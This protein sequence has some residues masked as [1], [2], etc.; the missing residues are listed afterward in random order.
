MHDHTLPIT[1]PRQFLGS[2]ERW[3]PWLAI[4]AVIAASGVASTGNL[5]YVMALLATLAGLVIAVYP[6]LLLWITIVAALVVAG[7]TRLYIPQ[8]QEVRWFVVPVALALLG[9]AL[10]SG[11]TMTPGPTRERL[12]ATLGW[13]LAFI[14]VV[15]FSTLLNRPGLEQAVIGF[16]GYFQVWGVL[17]ALAILRWPVELVDR[18]P[19][20][21]LWIGLLQLP[22]ALHQYLSMVPSRLGLGPGIVPLDVVSGTFGADSEGGGMNALLATY[23]FV[24]LAGL[25]ALWREQVLSGRRLLLLGLPLL[26]PVLLNEA[27][28]SVVY[29]LVV[30]LVLYRRDMVV[31]PA[32]FLGVMLG[33][34]LVL[35]MLMTVYTLNAPSDKVQGWADLVEYTYQYTVVRD[36]NQ[37]GQLGRWSA[38]TFWA[39]QHGPKDVLGTLL[40]HGV[41]ASR[42]AQADKLGPLAATLDPTM[43]IGNTA[44][45]AL[46]WES[47]VMGLL[48][49][50]GMLWAAFLSA[51]RLARRYATERWRAGLFQGLQAAVAVL[52]VSLWHKNLFVFQLSYQT[53]LVLLLGYLAYW[54]RAPSPGQSAPTLQHPLAR[55][56]YSRTWFRWG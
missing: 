8:L 38:L 5:I 1:K 37:A 56:A 14:L 49:V 39:S 18:L 33:A 6:T 25:T 19:K 31:R 10:L 4:L 55:G 15:V 28:V 44:V 43:G 53:L 51:G 21:L 16:K 3:S 27:K 7:L 12:P 9:H 36:E 48:C 20:V 52:F 22:F 29:L 2:A 13:A 45:A 35:G 41:G 40:G 50:F 47:G 26:V 23:L 30:F 24:V 34:A 17:F 11:F 32:R 46:L 42:A 54:E